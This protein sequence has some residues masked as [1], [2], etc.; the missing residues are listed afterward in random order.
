MQTE[1]V[2]KTHR[3]LVG[4]PVRKAPD[5]LRVHLSSLE[6][7]ILPPRVS[8]HYAFVDDNV[9]EE[10]SDLLRDFCQ[11]TGGTYLDA[12]APE[13]PPFSDANP[14][15]HH[16]SPEAMKRV[17]DAKNA[18]IREAITGGFDALWLVDADLILSPRTLWS[19]YYA[20]APIVCGVFWTRWQNLP[21]QPA[22][23]QAWLRHPY[24]LSGRGMEQ[25]EFLRRLVNRE[26][27]QVWGQG[28]CTLY[29]TEVL[30]KGVDFQF[31]DDLPKEGMW[32]GEDRH[33]CT[34]AE[35]LH[36]PMVA[37]AWPDIF[38]VYHP[39]QQ[40]EAPEWL[41][42]FLAEP[43]VDSPTRDD[44]VS[45]TTR[46]VEPVETGDGWRHLDP[47]H[48][49]G[50]LGRLAL[51]PELEAAVLTMTRGEERLLSVNY[52]PWSESPFRG[53]KRIMQ[54]RL[55][56]WKPMSLPVGL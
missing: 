24:E 2:Y 4:G 21:N 19:L 50:R 47:N 1:P 27:I 23:P 49:R 3:I 43:G 53:Q 11:K 45:L 20:E 26:R 9:V 29:R 7:Q 56:D 16:W 35:R 22:L 8:V 34:R 33:L 32:V 55:V 18:L 46:A 13:T 41:V 14:V 38:H 10:S 44:L 30:S 52:P 54:V 39:H 51:C 5:L 15:T 37:D 12:R 48:E 6:G 25:H 36:V 28:A 31:L 17:G 42:K 40:P